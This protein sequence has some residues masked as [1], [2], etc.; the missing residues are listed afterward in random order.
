MLYVGGINKYDTV[1]T[2]GHSEASVTIFFSGC[3]IRCEDCHNKELWDIK[4]GDVYNPFEL[5]D[6]VISYC[7]RANLKTVVIM[8]GE[9]IDQELNDL[10]YFMA[11]LSVHEI[12]MWVFTGYEFNDLPYFVK[13]LSSTIKTGRYDKTKHQDGFPASS[14]QKLMRKDSSGNWN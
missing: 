5:A 1:N 7:E 10:M 4:S 8:G 2:P 6:L 14:N 3:T 13:S 9:P 11:S 12:N